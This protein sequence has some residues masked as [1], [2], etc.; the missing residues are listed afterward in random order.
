MSQ[1]KLTGQNG[2]QFKLNVTQF[3]SP[4]SSSIDTVQTR[5]ALHHFPIRCGQPD[6]QFTV[7]FNSINAKHMFQN[8]VREHQVRAL[9]VDQNNARDVN[10]FWPERNIVNWTGYIS[11]FKV[12]ERRFEYAPVVTFGVD[13]VDSLMSEKTTIASTGS[14]IMSIIGPQIPAWNE[15]IDALITI[16]SR[17]ADQARQWVGI[18]LGGVG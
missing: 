12:I 6:I 3:R 10:L 13:L 2:A 14:D 18:P 5:R 7:Q 9:D 15:S 4:M 1:L 16:P 17:I 8:F 11:S